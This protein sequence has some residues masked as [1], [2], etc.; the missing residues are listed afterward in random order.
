MTILSVDLASNRYRDI[1][2]ALLALRDDSV[3]VEFIEPTTAG[4][5]D[6]PNVD[7]LAPWL[8]EL[9]ARYNVEMIF[10]DGPQGWKEPFNGLEH[11]RRCER[12]LATP[13]KTGLPGVVK[14]QSWTRMAAFSIDLFNALAEYGYP[15][16]AHANDLLAGRK[17][18]IESFPTSAWRTLSLAPLPGKARTSA[19]R[20][21][22][23]LTA[24]AGL[25]PL[26]LS[27][28][29]SHDELQALIA[30]LAGLP[31]LGHSKFVNRLFGSRPTRLEGTWREGFIMNPVISNEVFP[32]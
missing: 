15:R 19:T 27:R 18:A 2:V 22:S 24:L 10:I 26:S 9:A 4:L 28:P 1:G 31:W 17:V 12:E 32:A 29:P 6:R 5:R 14:P 21:T 3:V 23:G 8:M 20:L 30:G 16:L 25:V 13:E 7:V 11:S